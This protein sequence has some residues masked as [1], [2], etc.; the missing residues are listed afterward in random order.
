MATLD[1]IQLIEAARQSYV[2]REKIEA[3][4]YLREALNTVH[5]Q[6]LDEECGP[7]GVRRFGARASAIR[8]PA[9]GIGN[10]PTTATTP[11]PA[12]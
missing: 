11:V 5:Q 8:N 4:F 3:V 10:Q 7:D 1:P 6:V 2:A 9:S 12:S